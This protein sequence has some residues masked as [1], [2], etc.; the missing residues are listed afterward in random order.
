MSFRWS[1]S[2]Q[3]ASASQARILCHKQRKL[4]AQA[5]LLDQEILP[6]P[7]LRAT[8]PAH[9]QVHP[10]LQARLLLGLPAATM[11]TET[12]TVT[13]GMVTTAMG[14]GMGTAESGMGMAMEMCH[15]LAHFGKTV[16]HGLRCRSYAVLF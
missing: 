8:R 1:V 12:A 14:M 15:K 13:M 4:P 16:I 10:H 2:S 6:L 11:G 5:I 3:L 9:P 7:P